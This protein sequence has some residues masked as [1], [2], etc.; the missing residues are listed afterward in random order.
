MRLLAPDTRNSNKLRSSSNETSDSGGQGTDE[1]A[2]G[3][4]S[5]DSSK[6]SGRSGEASVIRY[7]PYATSKQHGDTTFPAWRLFF[8]K[9][10]HFSNILCNMSGRS[11]PRAQC[12]RMMP[13]LCSNS[14]L[15]IRPGQ[16]FTATNEG[17]ITKRQQ[18][19]CISVEYFRV[20]GQG[21]SH[22]H[23]CWEFLKQDNRVSVLGSRR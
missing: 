18:I 6:N 14:D 17:R 22:D 8:G 11:S 9:D 1:Q 7:K 13:Q 16:Y 19:N 23:L 10:K 5:S 20:Y 12:S 21:I 2:L 15:A 4:A 3:S